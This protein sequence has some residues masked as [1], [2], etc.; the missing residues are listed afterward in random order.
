MNYKKIYDSIIIRAQK[1][2]DLEKPYDKHHIIPRSLGGNNSKN[3]IVKLTLRE[4]FI[5][6]MLLSKIYGKTMICAAMMLSS[7]KRYNS[8]KYEWLRT[9]FIN[10]Y[11][12][13]NNNPIKRF[14]HTEERKQHFRETS[15][16]RKWIN[17]G[18][19]SCMAK[20]ERLHNLLENGWQLGRLKTE[21][22][23][24]GIRRGGK[25][26][27]GYNKGKHITEEQRT[28]ISKTALNRTQ[29][30]DYINPNAKK[31]TVI[32]PKGETFIVDGLITF[33]KK[34]DLGTS[35]AL[36][37]AGK[38]NRIVMRGKGAGWVAYEY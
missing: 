13:G 5:C 19:E 15:L 25:N 30:E 6:H 31:W 38:Q 33:C 14:P 12:T 18:T 32:S 21:T 2:N 9:H 27:G 37:N 24:N 11:M 20:S 16:G 1:R 22:L 17:N 4:H 28:Q 7:F 36:I 10:E 35:T 23:I 26:A 29:K 3:N 34:Y 8:K